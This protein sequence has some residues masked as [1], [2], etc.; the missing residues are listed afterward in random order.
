LPPAC[1]HADAGTVVRRPAAPNTEGT[2]LT[3][4]GDLGFSISVED[5]PPGR[6]TQRTLAGA[7]AASDPVREANRV[8]DRLGL[9]LT[10]DALGARTVLNV[11][12]ADLRRS[13][14]AGDVVPFRASSNYPAFIARGEVL[15][16]DADSGR[17]VTALPIAPNGQADW[18]VPEDAPARMSYTLRVY[19]AAGR[20]DET[21]PLP[22]ERTTTRL[23]AARSDGPVTAA[24]EAEDRTLRRRI[25]VR[26]AAVTVSGEDVPAFARITVR[27]EEVIP[28]PSRRF[29]IQRILPPGDHEVDAIVDGRRE[30]RVVTVPTREIFA[31][32][33]ADFTLG[34]DLQS[35][36][37]YRLGRISGFADGV[38]ANGTR[39]TASV[40]TREGE[41]R[42]LFS[43]FGRKFPDQVLRQIEDRDVWV[44]TGDDSRT[45][46]LAPT[47]GRFFLRAERD[48]S[49]LMWGDFRPDADLSRVV[50]TDRT[51]YGLSGTYRTPA[52][53]A[54]GEARAR[55]SVYASQPD[56]LAQRD[57]FRGTGG[58]AYFLSRRDIEAG[59]ETLIVETRG[60]DTGRVVSSRRLVEGRDYRIDY[61]QG[62]V[63]LTAPL[64][65]TAP[66]G[67]LVSDQPL[68][69]LV[70]NLVAQYEYVP[71]TGNVDGI[72]AGARGEVWLTDS[73]R[74]GASGVTEQ[75]GPADNTLQAMD[76]LW[77]RSPGTYL[78]FELAESEGPGFG[79]RLSLN[80]G[81]D[82]DPSTPDPG[83]A[84]TRARGLRVEGR[85]DLAE[86][87]LRGHISGWYDD[88]EAGFSSP[89]YAISTGREIAGID[90]RV[91]IGP[92]TDLTFGAERLREEG[93]RR[94]E[95]A[96][97]GFDTVVSPLLSV[98]GEIARTD[99]RTPGGTVARDNGSRTDAA[100]RLTW[101]RDADL[102]VYVF[103]QQTLE[104]SGGLGR[105]DRLGVGAEGQLTDRLR[106][107]FEVSDG[108][109][110]TAGLATLSYSPDDRTTYNFGYRLDPDRRQDVGTVRGQDNGTFVLGA[111]SRVNDR[112]S[113]TA[114]NTY[115]AFGSQPS[116]TTT[117][118]VSYTPS[119]VWRYDAGLIYGV[120]VEPDATEVER[121][122]LSFGLRYTSAEAF[123]ASLRA[124]YRRETSNNPT[125]LNDRTTYLLAAGVEART[126]DD[127]RAIGNVDAVWSD[128]DGNSF[129]DGRYVEARLGYAYR[130]AQDD[131]TNALVSYT[132]LY[133]LPGADQVNVDGNID[134]PKQRSHILNAAVSRALDDRFTLGLKYGL[135]IREEAPRGTDD[136]TRSIAHLG[137]GRLDYR[138]VNNWDVLGEVRVF[139]APEVDT[140]ETG[141]LLG[142]YREVTPTLRVGGGYLWGG[143]ND[144][145]RSFET[146]REGL[147]LNLIGKF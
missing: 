89:D 24:G 128:A 60:A 64:A 26:G 83:V 76:L 106:F 105:N 94:T 79:Q 115:S 75:S 131:R 25:P 2:V 96:R 52:T 146:A 138:I 98:A 110:G 93:G 77:Q 141:M 33:I 54:T 27:G 30:T 81:L 111:Q 117:Y 42:D 67:G 118:G 12:T 19:D 121:S 145:L 47:S 78:S 82:L 135:R 102:S 34:Y 126:S 13:Y 69:D 7:P 66:G 147:F 86:F 71:T 20:Y 104:R 65:P 35:R 49:H 144:D 74:L 68:G 87:G 16:L 120:T 90:G 62:V 48:G 127:W 72:S 125:R 10:R 108:S 40:D 103:G 28:D 143:V 29:V 137:I 31:T 70:V 5:G 32:G 45:E 61:V 136:F 80:G 55:I 91:G 100:L 130:P 101:S 53:T 99:R 116:L 6:G 18:A 122:G 41:L 97:L 112:W 46:N 124:E 113:Y 132:F 134:G 129:R 36:E 140:I 57:V 95:D 44:T 43:N 37:S 23:D 133:D 139:A 109:L 107:A 39:I 21:A 51:L 123:T 142:V 3:D 50:R 73:L 17:P 58:S 114:E 119:D 84:G 59:S 9:R 38:L 15:I 14:V 1:A 92:A 4:L 56:T 85:V 8:F 63:I 22:L 88:R 11:V